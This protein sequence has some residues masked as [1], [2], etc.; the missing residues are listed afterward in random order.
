MPHSPS[1]NSRD[2]YL[3]LLGFV[4]PYRKVF[5]LSMLGMAATAMTEPLFPAIMKKLLDSG[6]VAKDNSDLYLLPLAMVA[7]FVVRGI[8]TYFT[9]YS[10]AWVTNRLVMDLRRQMFGR[11]LRLPARYYD[12]QSPGA[13]IAKVAYDVNNVTAAATNVLTAL[14]RD[15]LTILGLL[16]FMLYYNW[17]LTLIALAVGPL[18]VGVVRVF[19]KRLRAASRR[20]YSAMG[21]IAHILEETIGAHKVVKVFGGQRYEAKRFDDVSNEFRKA[22]MRESMAASATVPLT[23]VAAAAALS[24]IIYVA[25]LQSAE[26]HITV[27]G[28]V[29]FI[30]AMLL[31]LAP[32]KRLTEVNAPLQRGLAAAESIFVLLD[33]PAEEDLGTKIL[34]RA[35]GDIRFDHV[36][37][38]YDEAVRPTLADVCL[39]VKAG[40]T[41][42]LVGPSGGGKTTLVTLI[43]RFYQTGSGSILIDGQDVQDLTLESLRQSIALVSQEVVLFND[44]VAA[45]IAYGASG[46]ASEAEIISA[47]KAA[48]AWEFISQMPQGLAT[49]VGENGVKLS[50]GQRQRLAIARAFLKNAPILILDE[51]TSALD[52][53]SERQI[54]SALDTLIQ[55]RTTLVIAHR[56]STVERADRIVV[57]DKGRI[58]EE[59]RHGELLAQNGIYTHLYRL[60]FDV[61]RA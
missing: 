16:G 53:E 20:G 17:R 15:S 1:A 29:S 10:L 40:Q 23:Q 33:Q 13:L 8:L 54:Q 55:G 35:R 31:L 41:V 42:A 61:G 60:Q 34:P 6:F 59:G 4:R 46:G 9:S 56:L 3:R 36:S 2:I 26:S 58:V 50:G 25:L 30:T 7:I 43:P 52:S 12:D 11:L 44:T 51:A 45:N 57:L 48:H 37:F 19:G 5:A 28:F 49:T 27:G 38:S 14:V 47:A 22:A 24:I 18:I 32:V 21:L 39:E